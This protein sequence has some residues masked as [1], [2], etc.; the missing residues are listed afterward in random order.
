MNFA[1]SAGAWDVGWEA[2]VAIATFLLALATWR[3]AR[4]TRSLADETKQE[5]SIAN[6]QVDEMAKQV[7]ATQK[8]VRI[9]NEQV[10]ASQAQTAAAQAAL[11]AQIRP[12]LIEVPI[13]P[14]EREVLEQVV[15]PNA[16]STGAYPGAVL[17]HLHENVALVSVPVRNAGTG[18]AMI[19]GAHIRTGLA[20]TET[21][22]VVIDPANLPPGAQGRVNFRAEPGPTCDAL[23]QAFNGGNF[24][25]V[26]TY[27][28]LAGEQLTTSRLDVYRRSRPPYSDW[29]VRQV[30]FEAPG[31]D[32][33]YAGSGPAF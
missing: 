10:T 13:V 8:H 6:R 22:P 21:V 3:L 27:A 17:A 15:W 9:A 32:T 7:V 25:V 16:P 18:L 30:H 4:S 29:D 1:A 24:S 12:V 33:P 20:A 31:S 28:D 2:L 19:R 11:R 23:S 26:V 14:G 5:V